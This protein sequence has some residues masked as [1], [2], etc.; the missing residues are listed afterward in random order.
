M[1][2][3]EKDS[4]RDRR[5]SAQENTSD[6]TPDTGYGIYPALQSFLDPVFT[7]D[8]AADRTTVATAGA[9]AGRTV[10]YTVTLRSFGFGPLTNVTALDL[11]PPQIALAEN[12]YV[13]GSTLVTYPDLFRRAP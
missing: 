1:R 8:K 3:Q 6:E 5:I 2:K 7:L 10:T 11:L 13:T 12:A 9:A 4:R